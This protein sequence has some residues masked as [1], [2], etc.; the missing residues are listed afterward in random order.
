MKRAAWR[1]TRRSRGV[2]E[3]RTSPA[4]YNGL[5]VTIL[6]MARQGTATARFLLAHG[7][8][9]TLSDLRSEL[10]LAGA[11]AELAA[12]ADAHPPATLRTVLGAHPLTLLDQTDLLCLSG[13]VSPAIPIVQEA[14][15]RSTSADDCAVAGCGR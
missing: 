11:C 13:G 1:R 12:Y 6:G 2:S 4:I 10:Q 9:V 15:R 8:R 7:A 5:R 14:V 3:A